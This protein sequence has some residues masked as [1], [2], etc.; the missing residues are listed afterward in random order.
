MKIGEDEYPASTITVKLATLDIDYMKLLAVAKWNS[1]PE[2][3]IRNIEA[4]RLKEFTAIINPKNGRLIHGLSALPSILVN[5]IAKDNGLVRVEIKNSLFAI[6]AW[7]MSKDLNF[8][9]TVDYRK[10]AGNAVNGTLYKL[11]QYVGRTNTLED[12]EHM[13]IKIL[14]RNSEEAFTDTKMI[15]NLFASVYQYTKQRTGQAGSRTGNA[16]NFES[17]LQQIESDFIIDCVYSKL[18]TL[19]LF[20]I[21]IRGSIFVKRDQAESVVKLMQSEAK[22]MGL[23]CTIDVV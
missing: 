17:A 15:S 16:V 23:L 20:A 7:S 12:A 8:I 19:G 2:S 1:M 4:I 22:T 21:P 11:V 6:L 3:V 14:L 10:F 5:T 9:Q 18:L 13:L